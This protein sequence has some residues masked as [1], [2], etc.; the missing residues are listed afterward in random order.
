M[1][2]GASK[3]NRRRLHQ[4]IGQPGPTHIPGLSKNF[5]HAP[6]G[7][8]VINSL[9]STPDLTPLRQLHTVTLESD[10][11]GRAEVIDGYGSEAGS[12][13]FPLKRIH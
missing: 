2:K 13:D 1:G 10:T 7:P 11:G 9:S 5:L 3:W 4:K 8:A 12:I 6:N